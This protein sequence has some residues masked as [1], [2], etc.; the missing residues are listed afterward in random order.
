L[1]ARSPCNL[2]GLSARSTIPL[3][4][5]EPPQR[6]SNLSP[7]PSPNGTRACRRWWQQ[8]TVGRELARTSGTGN[9]CCAMGSGSHRAPMVSARRGTA[10]PP[11]RCVL[12]FY[13][14][15]Q[16]DLDLDPAHRRRVRARDG[17]SRTER[18]F[19]PGPELGAAR[20][21]GVDS[22]RG[23]SPQRA[24]GSGSA[25]VGASPSRGLRVLVGGSEGVPEVV[26]RD[27]AAEDDA[28]DA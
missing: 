15:R 24:A 27:V 19:P 9:A 6:A 11:A 18:R 10:A 14:G 22:L 16:A 20:E 4:D 25:P 8:V 17:E 2:S 5:P 13:D 28:G 7:E 26:S 3:K 1:L 21:R 12:P 23:W